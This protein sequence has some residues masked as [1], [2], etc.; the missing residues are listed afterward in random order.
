[1]KRGIVRLSKAELT[2][3]TE[4]AE[5]RADLQLLAIRLSDSSEATVVTNAPEF[6]MDIQLSET[7]VEA[8]LDELGMPDSAVGKR[9]RASLLQFLQLS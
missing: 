9:L 5:K 1:M 4:I 6:Q 7:E 2:L 3:L 8:T